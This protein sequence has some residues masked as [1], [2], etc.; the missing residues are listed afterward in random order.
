METPT[1]DVLH[2]VAGEL[3]LIVANPPYMR[4]EAARAYR[5]GG[6]RFGEALSVRIVREALR[7]LAPGGTLLLYTGVAI[8]DGQDV[9]RAAIAELLTGSTHHYEE[10][11]PDVFG[12]Q[13]EQPGY[14]HVERIAAVGLTVEGF[15][16]GAR[17]LARRG[18]VSTS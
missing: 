14:E 11:D 7:R 6:G 17:R 12:E 13:L 3:D 2:G 10:L 15:R 1:S 4:D 9:F 8:V 16:D 5:D 18:Q